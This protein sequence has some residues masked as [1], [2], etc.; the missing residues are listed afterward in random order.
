MNRFLLLGFAALLFCT[1]A[2]G[3][4]CKVCKFK[5]GYLC[6]SSDDPCVAEEG[7]HCETTRV[8]S[9]KLMLFTRHG[10][11]KHKELC[12]LTE[13]RDNVFDMSYNR[14]CCNY[15]LCNGGIVS[16]PSLPLLAGLSLALGSWLAR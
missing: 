6:F 10:C 4:I 14:T 7:Q 9:G 15:D 2:Q 13:Q 5:V 16:G 8:Y 12:N 3:L 1:V 11:N